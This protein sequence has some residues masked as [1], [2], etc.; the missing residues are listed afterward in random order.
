MVPG[1]TCVKEGSSVIESHLGQ[2]QK[3]VTYVKRLIINQCF[4]FMSSLQCVIL[5]DNNIACHF[6]PLRN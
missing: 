3:R 4:H 5:T 1:Y 2:A 6:S